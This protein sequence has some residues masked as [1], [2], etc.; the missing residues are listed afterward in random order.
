MA[1]TDE[2]RAID[3]YMR[4]VIETT[5]DRAAQK[6]IEQHQAACK[7]HELKTEIWGN[8]T[9]QRPG[10]KLELHD[11]A[12]EVRSI[13]R[14][15]SGLVRFVRDNLAAPVL[16]AVIVAA[17]TGWMLRGNAAEAPPANPAAGGKQSARP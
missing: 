14:C 9:K 11:L 16:V 6:A 15:K 13:R 5:A 8:G 17:I 4:L 12:A 2:T 1:K 7:V 10:L 3:P